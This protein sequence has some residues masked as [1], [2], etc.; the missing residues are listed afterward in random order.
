VDE[1]FGLVAKLEVKIVERMA[2]GSVWRPGR[3]DG[4]GTGNQGEKKCSRQMGT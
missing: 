4:E 3:K 2:S 1:N